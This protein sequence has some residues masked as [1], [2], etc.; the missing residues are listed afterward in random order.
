MSKLKELSIKGWIATVLI[1]SSLTVVLISN[2]IYIRDTFSYFAI[3]GLLG[4]AIASCEGDSP[5]IQIGDSKNKNN[6]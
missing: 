4:L 6:D 1:F 2:D 5:I 3:F